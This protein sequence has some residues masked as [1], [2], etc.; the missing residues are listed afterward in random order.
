[1]NI[2]NLFLT[3]QSGEKGNVGGNILFLDKFCERAIRNQ[4][5]MIRYHLYVKHSYAVA[6]SQNLTSNKI[7]PPTKK[8]DVDLQRWYIHPFAAHKVTRKKQRESEKERKREN[9]KPT[10]ASQRDMKDQSFF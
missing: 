8:T 3:R 6:L 10:S 1:M 5:K 7:V 2:V 9:D 4:E